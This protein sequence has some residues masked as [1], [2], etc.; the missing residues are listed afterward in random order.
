MNQSKPCKSCNQ[1]LS[2]D[3]FHNS[4]GN[5]D[6]KRNICKS[7]IAKRDADRYRANPDKHRARGRERYANNR[8]SEAIRT[9]AKRDADPVAEAAR[10]R[11]RR[12]K[13]IDAY[14]VIEYNQRQKHRERRLAQQ[15]LRS[16]ETIELNLLKNNRRRA[17][18]NNAPTYLVTVKEIAKLKASLCF[19]CGA[20]GPKEIDH[21]IALTRGG[22]NGIG[23]YMAL[24]E[25]CNASKYNKTF[26]E[27]R[28]Y[29]I[30][31]GDPLPM[32]RK[33]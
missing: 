14:K 7:C 23:N 11:E 24:C 12:L 18:I 3:S 16:K 33:N 28:L 20:E 5:L 9:K 21:I 2:L 22:S 27:W 1:I 10:R 8:E 13:N 19:A 29:R 26:M 25:G 31:V 4:S 30:K 6:G 17:R 32:D 15:R